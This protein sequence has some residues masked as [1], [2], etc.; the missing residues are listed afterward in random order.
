MIRLRAAPHIPPHVLSPHVFDKEVI[1][2]ICLYADDIWLKCMSYIANTPVVLTQMNGP[3]IFDTATTAQ[4]GLAKINVEQNLN[5]KQLT[6]VTNYYAINW[7]E[8]L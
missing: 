4:N 2:E 6:D 8:Q 7:T 3:E 1:K 5:D